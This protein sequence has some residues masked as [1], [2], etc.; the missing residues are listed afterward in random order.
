MLE[1]GSTTVQTA[2]AERERSRGPRRFIRH[3]GLVSFY[4]LAYAL[5][6]LAWL[7]YILSE[8]GL[9]VLKFSFP[10]VFGTAQI[11]G[12]LLGAYLGPLGAAFIVTA[13][14]EGKTG[15]RRWRG[16]LL[17]FGVSP[18]WYVLAFFG[19]PILLIIGTLLVA[20]STVAGFRSPTL[21]LLLLYIPGLLIQVITTGLAEEPGWRDFALVRHQQQQGPLVGTLILSGLWALWH[22]PLFLTEWGAGLGGFNLTAAATFTAFCVAISIVI[23]WV[24]NKTGGSLPLAILVHVSNNNFATVLWFAMFTTLAPQKALT[25]ALVGFGVMALILLV[26][27]RGQLGYRRNSAADDSVQVL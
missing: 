17:H 18:R 10:K 5:S 26:A 16:R 11:T 25:G 3:H 9:G 15:L 24:F 19:V 6:W 8:D 14:S 12:M 23:T 21:Q 13:I 2:V 7:P 22:F 4:A 27:T 20:P 1:Q